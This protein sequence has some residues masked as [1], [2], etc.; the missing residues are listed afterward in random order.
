MCLYWINI[1]EILKSGCV[2]ISGNIRWLAVFFI[3]HLHIH[4]HTN[5]I[6]NFILI[7]KPHMNTY[8]YTEDILPGVC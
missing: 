1:V 3:V 7:S 8:I 6:I 5:V 4:V 2:F